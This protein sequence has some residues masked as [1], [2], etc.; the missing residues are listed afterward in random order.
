M[1]L[2]VS[3][4]LNIAIYFYAAS[5]GEVLPL[6]AE[7]AFYL[8][9]FIAKTASTKL[10]LFPWH[11]SA[12]ETWRFTNIYQFHFSSPWPFPCIG[13]RNPHSFLNTFCVLFLGTHRACFLCCWWTVSHSLLCCRYSLPR[14][15]SACPRCLILLPLHVH[16]HILV[17][18]EWSQW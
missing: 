12:S 13:N 9:V 1:H 6:P 7:D 17:V 10:S 11:L 4:H 5:L 2:N 8:W 14:L 16:S 3:M 18:C 15:F